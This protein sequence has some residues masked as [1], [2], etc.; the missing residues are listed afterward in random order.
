MI[1]TSMLAASS[2]VAARRFSARWQRRP[3]SVIGAVPRNDRCGA[4]VVTPILGWITPLYRAVVAWRPRDI[5]RGCSGCD[6]ALGTR[7]ERP[8]YLQVLPPPPVRAAEEGPL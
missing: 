1:A 6:S 7:G 4:R 3:E 8:G 5:L 2:A